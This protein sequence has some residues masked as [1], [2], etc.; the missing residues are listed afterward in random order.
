MSYPVVIR[1]LPSQNEV[2]YRFV[3]ASPAAVNNGTIMFPSET[4]IGG[5]RDVYMP[6]VSTKNP[7]NMWIATG[8]E[9]M[10]ETG[11]HLDD[12][13]NVT[14]QNTIPPKAMYRIERIVEGCIYAISSDGFIFNSTQSSDLVVGGKAWLSP[15]SQQT[16]TLSAPSATV[17]SYTQ[18]GTI[19]DVYTK[20]G[21]TFASI[22]FHIP[23]S[24]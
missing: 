24:F 18:I 13:T 7:N 16:I 2:D 3:A 6:A 19:I 9:A 22:M 23:A 12:Y 10:Y 15:G 17:S 21:K 14:S 4:I 8:V 1:E 5:T 20:G 11:K